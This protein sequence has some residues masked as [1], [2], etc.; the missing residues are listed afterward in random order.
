MKIGIDFGTTNTTI[1]YLENKTIQQYRLGGAGQDGYVPSWIAY[2]LDDNGQPCRTHL[3]HCEIG[4]NARQVVTDS[5]YKTYQRFK[6]FLGQEKEY[7]TLAAQ[8]QA[9]QPWGYETTLLP[10]IAAQD[11]LDL[12]LTA[13]KKEK[14]I[15]QIEKIVLT[16]PLVWETAQPH[17]REQLRHI[18]EN[19][20]YRPEQLILRSEPAA[21]VVYFAWKYRE[22]YK[23]SFT[24]KVL[25][26]DYG[27]GTLDVSVAEVEGLQIHIIRQSGHGN[28]TQFL[29]SAG[30]AFD[31]AVLENCLK[32]QTDS[33][34][35][36]AFTIN[37]WLIEFET[38]KIASSE[39]MTRCIAEAL[40]HSQTGMIR[41]PKLFEVQR[42]KI[43][44]EDLI[45]AFQTVNAPAL[46]QALTEIQSALPTDI[47]NATHF[48]IVLVGGFSQFC[49][50]RY[51][52][53]HFLGIR[54]DPALQDPR[55]ETG[56]ELTEGAFAIANGA[57]LVAN[58]LADIK[59]SIPFEIG[60]LGFLPHPTAGIS[61]RYLPIIKQ[62]TPQQLCTQ[63]I[64]YPHPFVVIGD[65]PQVIFYLRTNTSPALEFD[66]QK[67][68]GPAHEWLPDFQVGQKDE[69]RFK[70]GFAIDE[71]MLLKIY[72]HNE[73]TQSIQSLTLG[74]MI[75]RARRRMH[76]LTNPET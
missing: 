29:G 41:T 23:K 12:L 65:Q 30:V 31:Q 58:K 51:T 4:K 48:R 1:S 40:D 11:Y 3:N 22:K 46:R 14:K 75:I 8:Q 73:R 25:V 76:A 66:M 34:N 45:H 64:Y 27:G 54:Y 38:K 19:L 9:L 35:L 42:M 2:P 56:F 74:D 24:G 52:L 37:E 60:L 13:F 71:N 55:F 39:K 5:D 15:E 49:L 28:L 59:Q 18:F 17:A 50:V 72:F 63:P 32:K 44:P 36:D 53:C 21:A 47:K 62:G 20:G 43:M 16:M 69:T 6:L 67:K 33:L 10:S 61:K 68:Y 26:I 7:A 70:I 57:A